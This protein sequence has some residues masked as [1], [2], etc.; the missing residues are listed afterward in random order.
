M[1]LFLL[2]LLCLT[3]AA[4]TDRGAITGAVTDI[5]GA[6]IPGVSVIAV[7]LDTNLQFRAVATQ[8]GEF[9]LP[10]LP[11]GAYRVTVGESNN[12]GGRATHPAYMDYRKR[13]RRQH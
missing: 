8:S 9:V 11:V 2:P 5:I 13:H 6:A 7:Q 4:Q 1:R 12:C 10:S 3:L